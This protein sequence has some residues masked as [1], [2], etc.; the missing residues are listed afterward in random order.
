MPTE[1]PAVRRRR[2]SPRL[3]LPARL[4][5]YILGEVIGPF[6][7][8]V[9]FFIFLFLMFRALSLAELL[10]VHGASAATLGKM[11]MLMTIQFLPMVLPVAFLIAVLVG[12]GR[13]SSDSELVAFKASG[14]SIWRMSVP[15]MVLSLFV[16]ALSLGLNMEWSPWS[17]SASKNLLIKLSNTKVASSIKEGT[18]TS[19][20]FDLLIYAEKVDQRTSRMK[21]VFIYDERNPKTPFTV[22][23]RT[24]EIVPV[25]TA[26]ELG[27]AAMLKLYNG[28]IHRSDSG[29]KLY[30]K[31]DFETY[32]LYLKIDEGAPNASWKPGMI[33]YRDL[34]R[35]IR[36]SSPT[37]PEGREMRGEFW[38]RYAIAFA[39][40]IFVYL[41][42]G[43][44]T[45]RTRAVRA[46]AA[47]VA[48]ITLLVYWTLLSAASMA[49]HRGVL[50]P[51]IAMWIPNLVVLMAAAFSFQRARW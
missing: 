9:V 39:P 30:Q 3:L 28:S 37:S 31:I 46:G 10:I 34:R 48:F 45:V 26:S 51:I 47:L 20:F 15:V 21:R 1:A 43:F 29:G 4:D 50:P 49:I 7:G 33:P 6:L 25:R 44:G 36:E 22:V 16:V 38:R 11:T 14:V 19:G 24:G 2:F 41:G 8:G 40:L 13:L 35:I 42:M 18:F 17:E 5:R 12:F 27:S 23:A 32:R